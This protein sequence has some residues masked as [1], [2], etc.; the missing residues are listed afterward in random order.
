MRRGQRA[1]I[2]RGWT[3]RNT[4][5]GFAC[6]AQAAR[7]WLEEHERA[8]ARGHLPR[9]TTPTTRQAIPW[10]DHPSPRATPC[11]SGRPSVPSQLF[12]KSPFYQTTA[13]RSSSPQWSKPVPATRTE[14]DDDHEMWYSSYQL[15]ERNFNGRVL[16]RPASSRM[17]A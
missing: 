8:G 14:Y 2:S 7:P 1:R 10:N 15:T 12:D 5:S 16:W 6:R 3:K 9:R 4:S 17:P 11:S 13:S